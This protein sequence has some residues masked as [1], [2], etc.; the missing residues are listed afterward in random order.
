MHKELKQRLTLGPIMGA[1]AISSVMFDMAY[2]VT[3][4]VSALICI[5]FIC[6]AIEI[7]GI[8]RHIDAPFSRPAL[9]ICGLLLL[10]WQIT[11]G[12]ACPLLEMLAGVPVPSFIFAIAFIWMCLAHLRSSG[13]AGFLRSLGMG[14]FSL[15]YLGIS[16]SLMLALSALPDQAG[17]VYES[18]Q[19]QQTR[20]HQLLLLL[21]AACKL[22]DVS[23]YFGGRAFGK[24]KLAP[25]VSP[26][27]T[28]AGF[29]AAILGSIAGT[30]LFCGIFYAMDLPLAFNGWWQALVWGLICGPIGVLGDLVESC[31]KREADIKD[32]GS[33]L[34]GFGGFLDV[35]DAVIFCAP[36]AYAL[37]L[38]LP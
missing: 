38:I 21:C 12:T 8:A 11:L 33:I 28:W 30:Y 16:C 3:Y 18:G 4:G 31:L 23:A 14:S 5:G 32:S 25:R 27:K 7:T 19:W 29:Y 6:A 2:G 15:I 26:G 34:P 17:I 1:I 22:G 10:A 24:K 20:G 36:V 37:A 9:L 13:H 35:F